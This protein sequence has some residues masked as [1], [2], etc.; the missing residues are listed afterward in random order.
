MEPRIL[1]DSQRDR[2]G[3]GAGQLTHPPPSPS[4]LS[5]VVSE[6]LLVIDHLS[7]AL[8]TLGQRLLPVRTM[9]PPVPVPSATDVGTAPTPDS[10]ALVLEMHTRRLRHLLEGVERITSELDV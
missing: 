5:A 8:A 1:Y 9:P 6:Q 3:L 10:L 2:G 7:S 4:R